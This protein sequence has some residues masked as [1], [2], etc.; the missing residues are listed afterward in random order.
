MLNIASYLAR[1]GH[2]VT[3][4]YS[5]APFHQIVNNIVKDLDVQRLTLIR[6]PYIKVPTIETPLVLINNEL[7]RIL[8][9]SDIV[10]VHFAPPNDIILALM[11]QFSFR[12]IRSH[13]I[14]GIHQDPFVSKLKMRLYR[15]LVMPISIRIFSCYHVLNTYTL[16]KLVNN[17]RISRNKIFLIPNG[18]KIERFESCSDIR[19]PDMFTVLYVGKLCIEKGVPIL[20]NIVK[21]I[22]RSELRDRIRFFIAGQ[23]PLAPL[24]RKISSKYNNVVYL[25][26]VEPSQIAS[27]YKN[28]HV[29]LLPSLSEMMPLTI[30]EAQYCGLP[31]VT[32]DLP[33]LREIVKLGHGIIVQKYNVNSF[34]QAIRFYFNLWYNDREGYIEMMESIRSEAIQKYD[35]RRML[36]MFEKMLIKCLDID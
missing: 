20:L 28:S 5:L 22:N 16:N 31:V 30:I 8:N 21:E 34:I 24:V 10:Y 29:L 6:M 35:I 17:F 11:K 15:R 26:Y 23:G 32:T 25:G 13:F 36:R 12:K 27:I 7:S 3:I 2:E 1:Q 18:V 9:S 4:L 33:T 14:L 19:K